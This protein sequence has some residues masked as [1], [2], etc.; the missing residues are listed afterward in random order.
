MGSARGFPSLSAYFPHRRSLIWNMDSILCV[1]NS[2]LNLHLFLRHWFDS[3]L[4]RLS[5]RWMCP[6]KCQ[7]TTPSEPGSH[8]AHRPHDYW[9]EC[10]SSFVHAYMLLHAHEFVSTLVHDRTASNDYFHYRLMWR[11][12]LRLINYSM[13]CQRSAKNV[14][15]NFP[16]PVVVSSDCFFC[17]N[18]NLKH[19]DSS[20]MI[21][22]TQRSSTSSHLRG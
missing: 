12:F 16:E 21:I 22:M 19:K 7:T 17:P 2:T 20:F 15:L 5:L 1:F 6:R 3:R 11:L 8:A 4:L 9:C 18:N 13:K 14:R 10:V